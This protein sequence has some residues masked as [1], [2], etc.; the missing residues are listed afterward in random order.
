LLNILVIQWAESHYLANQKWHK[1]NVIYTPCFFLCMRVGKQQKD[2]QH[3][4]TS[5][6]C[7]SDTNVSVTNLLLCLSSHIPESLIYQKLG[8]QLRE[9]QIKFPAFQSRTRDFFR[10]NAQFPSS[11]IKS[12]YIKTRDK[13]SFLLIYLLRSFAPSTL[14]SNENPRARARTHAIHTRTDHDHRRTW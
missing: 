13:M 14:A 1:C 2:L 11:L 9:T 8:I 5:F 4:L 7:T 6:V 12:Y 10:T 3:W